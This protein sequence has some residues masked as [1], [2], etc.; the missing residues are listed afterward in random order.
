M[1]AHSND[2]RFAKIVRSVRHPS[3]E[4]ST[5]TERIASNANIKDDSPDQKRIKTTDNAMSL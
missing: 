5:H 4:R 1:T 2:M 3:D